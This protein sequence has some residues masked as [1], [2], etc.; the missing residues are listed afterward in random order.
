MRDALVL[1]PLPLDIL[2]IVLSLAVGAFAF[3]AGCWSL[4]RP[5]VRNSLIAL[6]IGLTSLVI[7]SMALILPSAIYETTLEIGG[8]AV[9]LS[10]MGLLILGMVW[11]R[12]PARTWKSRLALY[13]T[14]AVGAV[15]VLQTG[16]CLWWRWCVPELWQRSADSRGGARQSTGWTCYP[17]AGVMLLHRHGIAATEGEM[18]YLA[19]TTLWGTE[20]HAMARALTIKGRAGG[21]RAE[22]EATDYE[23][24]VRHGGP[25]IASV[26]SLN[27]GPHVIFVKRA[28]QD[29]LE[30]IDPLDGV[31]RKRPRAAFER[32]W[33][34]RTVR[35]VSTGDKN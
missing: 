30:V 14:A 17:A 35:L 26:I 2:G 32:V 25:F 33:T 6:A 34:G 4:S 9:V 31:E 13:A 24:C 5:L 29:H 23:A 16:A 18:A 10:W 19:N 1:R 22:V 11:G 28:R 20:D 8:A 27:I 3:A 15:I 7:A 12:M 21:W